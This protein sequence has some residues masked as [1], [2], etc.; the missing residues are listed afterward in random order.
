M[1]IQGALVTY[2]EGEKN[3]G[4]LLVVIGLA[5]LAAAAVFFQARWGLRSLAV[6]LAVLSVIETAIGAGLYLR[7][8]P[9]VNRLLTQ[10]RSSPTPFYSDETARMTQVQRVAVEPA[11][12]VASLFGRTETA[13]PRPIDSRLL[14]AHDCPRGAPC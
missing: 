9:Q 14:R 5:G 1:D 13:E 12:V 7:T 4:V 11:F 3:A 6:T 2:F 8:G 10:L